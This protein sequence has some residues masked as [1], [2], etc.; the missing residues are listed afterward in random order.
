MNDQHLC[1]R[2]PDVDALAASNSLADLAF[3]IQQEHNAVAGA[4]K[5]SLAHAMAAGDLLLQAKA[6]LTHGQW[7]PWLREHCHVSER[8]AQRYIRLAR[9]R[10]LIEAK[11]DTVSDL[12]VG[13]ALTLI[14]VSRSSSDEHV[15]DCIDLADHAADMASDMQAYFEVP[16]VES[17]MRKSLLAEARAAIE[18]I[19]GL[20]IP[21]PIVDLI[22]RET[23]DV[24]DRFMAAVDLYSTASLADM[25][26]S[27][28]E[29][30]QFQAT[31]EHAKSQGEDDEQ[32]VRIALKTF[33]RNFW[34]REPQPGPA[35]ITVLISVRDI[36]IE[37]VSQIEAIVI[38]E[39]SRS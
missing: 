21:S 15:T 3:R 11:C 29:W 6:K 5:S 34:E 26:L 8:M 19:A 25:G 18:S 10:A 31:V 2:K 35:P 13:G 30:N 16:E 20:S 22:E 27:A 38:R 7:L 37:Y 24:F 14:S 36:A 23:R 1:P 39:G 32:V 9:N 4:L 28:D 12:G 33:G 17:K